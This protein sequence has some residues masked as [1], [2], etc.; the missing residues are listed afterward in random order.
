MRSID[1]SCRPTALDLEAESD[2][3]PNSEGHHSASLDLNGPTHVRLQPRPSWQVRR[4]LVRARTGL[5]HL[6]LGKVSKAIRQITELMAAGDVALHAR[7]HAA[8]NEIRACALLAED[9][10]RGARALLRSSARAATPGT[11]SATLLR[12]L[13]WLSG[14]RA[15]LPG[16]VP[17]LSPVMPGRSSALARILGLCWN[18]ALEFEHLRP[19][20]AAHLAAEALQLATL[21]YGASSPGASLPAVLLAQI[22][23]EQGRLTE[24]EGLLRPRAETILATGVLE[25]VWR[26]C[27]VRVR[28]S[29]CHGRTAEAF[30]SLRE[31]E[32]IGRM[33]GWRRLVSLARAERAR[34]R[35]VNTHRNPTYQAQMAESGAFGPASPELLPRYSCLHSALAQVASGSSSLSREERYRVLTSCLQIG[36]TRGLYRLFVDAGAPILR[37]VED[38]YDEPRLLQAQPYD[39]RPYLGL[40]LSAGVRTPSVSRHPFVH[41]HRPLSRRE[42]DIL[43]MIAQ[44]LPNKRIAQSLGIGPETVKS[45]AKSIFFKL[46]TRTRAQAVARAASVDLTYEEAIRRDAR[47]APGSL[48]LTS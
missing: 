42:K 35:L 20:V 43:R 46:G 12:Y 25:C 36:A 8:F 17:P 39:L 19:T 22:A 13:E 2:N 24:A 9:D 47:A 1:D 14:A 18:A 7:Y 21:R 37:L 44:G 32:A 48:P 4:A 38:L 3:P 34:L 45:H 15:E 30:A 31:A 16:R 28:I 10:L 5:L 41:P 6:R 29:L 26:A 33:R 23:Y 11:I 40:L 27:L